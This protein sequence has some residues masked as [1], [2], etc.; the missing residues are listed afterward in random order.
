MFYSCVSLCVLGLVSTCGR[1]TA[2]TSSATWQFPLL[3]NDGLTVNYIDT[4]VFQ[5][6]SNYPTGWLNFWCQNGTTG[7]NVTLGLLNRPILSGRHVL[8]FIP[9]REPIPSPT[10]WK[11]SIHYVVGRS[12]A[13]SIPSCMSCRA[14]TSPRT[15]RRE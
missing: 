12:K 9:G 10:I 6:T 2:Q 1:A 4:V 13:I 11:L 8:T 7:N 3:E 5:W 14:R 15:T